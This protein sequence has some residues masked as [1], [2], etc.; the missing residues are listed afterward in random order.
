MLFHNR[1]NGLV[2]FREKGPRHTSQITKSFG[3]LPSMP[4]NTS[5]LKRAEETFISSDSDQF[6]LEGS[7]ETAREKNLSVA[8]TKPVTNFVACRNS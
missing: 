4:F 5:F 2:A 6:W 1:W 3:R 7:G 8:V